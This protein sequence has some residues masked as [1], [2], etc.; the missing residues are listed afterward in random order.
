MVLLVE[1]YSTLNICFSLLVLLGGK[2]E[3]G[4][5]SLDTHIQAG[6]EFQKVLEERGWLG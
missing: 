6:L 5:S 2:K 4:I 3:Y 1:F